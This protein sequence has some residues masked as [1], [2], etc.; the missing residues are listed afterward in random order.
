MCGRNLHR[1]GTE[2]L[3][4]SQICGAGMDIKSSSH[5]ENMVSKCDRKRRA[6]FLL[7]TPAGNF[8]KGWATLFL[9]RQLQVGRVIV[10]CSRRVPH[11]RVSKTKQ[12]INK[13]VQG[14]SWGW[15]FKE[16]LRNKLRFPWDWAEVLSMAHIVQ[17]L[18][19]VGWPALF[20]I[21]CTHRWAR[22][23]VSLR[24]Q[25]LRLNTRTQND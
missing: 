23:K 10:G 14:I 12:S 7:A 18:N 3:E 2:E 8:F 13:L 21:M 6:K 5:F 17:I 11:S 25:N 4:W 22:P 24:W 16:L 9:W 20:S 15:N 19:W 1:E